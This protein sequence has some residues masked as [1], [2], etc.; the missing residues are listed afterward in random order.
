MLIW[1]YGWARVGAVNGQKATAH[2]CPAS[3]Q[4]PTDLQQNSSQRLMT[5]NSFLVFEVFAVQT[6]D[7][8]DAWPGALCPILTSV[9]W[10][11]LLGLPN[12]MLPL[13]CMA[14]S[15]H[16]NVTRYVLSPRCY[17]SSVLLQYT[18]EKILL[19]FWSCVPIYTVI[20]PW[21]MVAPDDLFLL[22]RTH[23]SLYEHNIIIDCNAKLSNSR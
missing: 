12:C 1:W 21:M 6:N 3:F 2:P 20:R 9:C 15:S 17:S 14:L 8:L 10:K 19:D 7:S 5:R 13:R 4:K 11:L 23:E 22:R 16:S 18:I